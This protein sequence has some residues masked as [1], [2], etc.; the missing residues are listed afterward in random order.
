[1][2]RVSLVWSLILKIDIAV[3]KSQFARGALS[4]SNA[5]TDLIVSLACRKSLGTKEQDLT[6]LHRKDPRLSK[7][8]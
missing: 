1:M 7:T 3:E 6:K 4:Y 5:Q 8:N 2:G